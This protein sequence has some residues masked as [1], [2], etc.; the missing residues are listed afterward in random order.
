MFPI[1]VLVGLLFGGVDQYLG[2]IASMPWATSVSLLSAPWLV[3]PF[4][5]GCTQRTRSSALIIGLVVTYSAL[6]GY[7]AMTLSPMEGVHLAQ[8]HDAIRGLL[9][10]ERR[11]FIG[12]L[13]T[14][15]LYGLLGHYWRKRR[16]CLSAALVAGAVCFEPL[17]ESAVGQLPH[18]SVVWLAEIAVGTAMAVYFAMAFTA[19][20]RSHLHA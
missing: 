12:G 17:A 18:Q 8:Q 9:H 19:D 2:S 15:P 6:L 1:A 11:F 10:S 5:F 3:V 13:L 14:G 16:A 4:C 7:G 20:R